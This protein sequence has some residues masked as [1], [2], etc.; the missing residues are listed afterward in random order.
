MRENEDK[1]LGANV[2]VSDDFE[3]IRG[4]LFNTY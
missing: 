4:I 2:V 3:V 1:V